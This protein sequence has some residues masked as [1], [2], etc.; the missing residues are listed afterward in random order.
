M[1]HAKKIIRLLILSIIPVFLIALLIFTVVFLMHPIGPVLPKDVAVPGAVTTTAGPLCDSTIPATPGD[2]DLCGRDNQTKSPDEDRTTI[3]P[4]AR[5]R[6]I[7]SFGQDQISTGQSV[8]T[9]NRGTLHPLINT[10]EEAIA[11]YFYPNGPVLGYGR[12]M[13]GSLVVWIDE[14]QDVNLTVINEIYQR[15]SASGHNYYPGSVP[16]RFIQTGKLILD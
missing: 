11:P 14:G 3:P 7:A 16:C 12:D 10:T 15:I 13:N 8:F 1:I 9:D 2:Q 4:A 6:V 5:E